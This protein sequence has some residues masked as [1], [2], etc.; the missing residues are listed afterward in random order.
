LPSDLRNRNDRTVRLQECLDRLRGEADEKAAHRQ[1]RIDAR[2]AEEKATGKPKRGRKPKPVDAVADEDAK[3]NT[4]DPDSRIMKGSRGWLQGCNARAVVTRDQIIPA[5]DVTSQAND[6]QQL[7]PM[8]DKA[9]GMTRTVMGEEARP[10]TALMDAGYWS[11]ANAALETADCEYMI[12]TTRDWKQRKAMREAPPP[13]GRIPKSLAT[14][15]RMER[16]LLTKRGRNLYRLR[17]QTVEPVFG[18]ARETQGADRFMMRGEQATRGE[19][20]LHCSVHNL[21]KMHKE[22]LRRGIEADTG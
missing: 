15:E 14:G 18:Q 11:E 10:G 13:R 17:G 5:S 9:R 12:A 22:M 20:N 8:L 21:R 19:W 6:V 7:G 4:T 1:D 16:K 2:A 3:A